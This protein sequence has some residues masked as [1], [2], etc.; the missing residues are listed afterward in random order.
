VKSYEI[1][2]HTADIAIRVRGSDLGELFCNAALAVFDI[3]S[4]RKNI[5]P[6]EHKKIQIKQ[7]A[8]NL[9]ELFVNWLNELLSLAEAKGLIFFRFYINTIGNNSL[10]AIAVGEKR[11][12]Y[13]VNKEIKAA[14][15]HE[16]KISEGASGWQAEVILDV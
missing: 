11:D 2:E 12:G 15:Y 10:D 16:L 5:N 14:T 6:R 13:A 3:I 9:E 7:R 1:I 8:D 4:K